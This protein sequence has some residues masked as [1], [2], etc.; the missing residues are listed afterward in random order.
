MAPSILVSAP[1]PDEVV[2][3]AVREFGAIVA[4]ERSLSAAEIID[5]AHAHQLRGLL[6]TSRVKLDRTTIL[7]LPETVRVLATYS[8]G[9]DHIEVA[10][11]AE[12]GIIVTNTPDVLTDATADITMMLILCACRRAAEYLAVMRAG[13]GVR[14]EPNEL[15]GV[16]VTG[17]TLGILGFGRI[18]QAVAR[19]A[20]GF[21]MKLLY[22]NP[23]P[24]AAA[25]ALG[26]R[27]VPTFHAML[28]ETDILTLH[29][30]GGPATDGILDTAALAAL[31]PGA[32]IVNAAR[33]QLVDEDALIDALKRGHV[34]AAGLDVFRG[35][36]N[37]D[38]R[39]QVLPNVFLTPHMGSA[40]IE[41][42][43]AMGHRALD[44]IAAVLGG[45]T[46]LDPI[47]AARIG[48]S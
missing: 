24:V 1:L 16:Q 25:Q 11:A 40:T 38:P 17:K 3:R 45:D 21:G 22:H 18:G 41:T 2:T 10:A 36:P 26:A 34:R 13:W 8:V 4:Q 27:Y 42:R 19:R 44:N 37:L 39:F 20:Q 31:R 7:S 46:P 6:V 35:E 14:H 23:E 29:A 43:N 12:R 9:Y 5:L 33:G 32:V 30:P 47:V 28:R 48:Q 15:L